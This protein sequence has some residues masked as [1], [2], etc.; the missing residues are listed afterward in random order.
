MFLK[1]YT[2]YELEKVGLRSVERATVRRTSGAHQSLKHRSQ[3]VF[4]NAFETVRAA[5]R[6]AYSRIEWAEKSMLPN[7]LWV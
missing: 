2:G 6:S 7:N 1:A 5:F 4:K 3:Q